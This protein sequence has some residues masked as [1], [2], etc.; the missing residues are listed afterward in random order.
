MFGVLGAGL[1]R[2]RKMKVL[3]GKKSGRCCQETMDLA[4]AV[5]SFSQRHGVSH[6]RTY[7]PAIGCKV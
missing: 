1:Y 2:R 3:Q 5:N 7:S 4:S 6:R